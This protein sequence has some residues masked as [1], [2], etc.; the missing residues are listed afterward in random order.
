[1]IPGIIDNTQREVRAVEMEEG[2]QRMFIDNYKIQ[3]GTEVY[4][5]KPKISSY[6]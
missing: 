5:L 6:S 2:R 3:K 4:D 1:V